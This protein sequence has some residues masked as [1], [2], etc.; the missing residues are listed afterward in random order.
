MT[1]KIRQGVKAPDNTMPTQIRIDK[2]QLDLLRVIAAIEGKTI[3]GIVRDCIGRYIGETAGSDDLLMATLKRKFP[4][5]KEGLELLHEEAK[6]LIEKGQTYHD[7]PDPLD[8][9]K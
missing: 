4:H 2:D 3:S 5:M 7:L 1:T 9:E 8:E 6:A